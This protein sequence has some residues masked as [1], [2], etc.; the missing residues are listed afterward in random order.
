M[1]KYGPISSVH[2]DCI[3]PQPGS[4]AKGMEFGSTPISDGQAPTKGVLDEVQYS[5][6]PGEGKSVS[7]PGGGGGNKL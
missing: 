2:I 5:S 4:P 6:M 7:I 3:V 1:K